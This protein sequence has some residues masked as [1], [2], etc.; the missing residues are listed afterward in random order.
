MTTWDE[1]TGGLTRTMF[2]LQPGSYVIIEPV[3]APDTGW[4]QF[5]TAYDVP[6]LLLQCRNNN[7]PDEVRQQRASTGWTA[8]DRMHWSRNLTWPAYS[9]EYTEHAQALTTILREQVETPEQLAYTAWRDPYTDPNGHVITDS[10]Q[11]QLTLPH[12][13][14]TRTNQ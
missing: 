3:N 10:S 5:R 9:T 11:L 8:E 6:D 7:D 1:F 12:L 2:E 14:I 13:G 4:V